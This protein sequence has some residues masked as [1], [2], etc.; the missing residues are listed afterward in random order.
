MRGR[1]DVVERDCGQSNCQGKVA[2]VWKR[3]VFSYSFMVLKT[4][5]RVSETVTRP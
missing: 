1:L 4:F 3:N 2:M 5:L